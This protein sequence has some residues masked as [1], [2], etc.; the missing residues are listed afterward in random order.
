MGS[1][2]FAHL[3]GSSDSMTNTDILVTVVATTRED[4]ALTI[5]RPGYPDY[6]HKH[7][8]TPGCLSSDEP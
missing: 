3:G 4:C 1:P 5:P 7:Q 8:P 2:K 6:Y